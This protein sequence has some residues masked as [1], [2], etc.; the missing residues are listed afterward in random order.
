MPNCEKAQLPI[1]SPAELQFIPNWYTGPCF[2]GIIDKG[3]N[4]IIIRDYSSYIQFGDS[5]RVEIGNLDC[6]SAKL[7][8]IDFDNYILV[9]KYTFGAGCFSKFDRNIYFDDINKTISY[10][11]EANYFGICKALLGSLNWVLIPKKYK[12]YTVQFEVKD[13]YY[14]DPSYF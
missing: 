2:T 6:E 1:E 5:V 10:N 8:D 3:Y 9:G 4:E 14:K 11:I 7:P 13:T 12:D